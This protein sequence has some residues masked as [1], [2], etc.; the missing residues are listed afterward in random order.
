MILRPRDT[1]IFEAIQR[2][3]PLPTHYLYEFSKVAA[4]DY[5]GFQK[6]LVALFRAGLLDRPQT[7]NN[8]LIKTD[9]K[10]YV[11]TKKSEEVLATVGK[12]DRFASPVGGGYQHAF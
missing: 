7:L 9:F 4:K 8:P 11:L 1:L 3:G 12:R 2:H 6:R 5:T 10:V